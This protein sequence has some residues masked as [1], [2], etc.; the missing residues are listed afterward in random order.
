MASA[1]AVYEVASL[2]RPLPYPRW[3]VY[4]ASICAGRMS[5]RVKVTALILAASLSAAANAAEGNWARVGEALGKTGAELPG[6]I[7]RVALPRTDLKVTLDGVDI[8]PGL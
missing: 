3:Q 2:S 7:Y 6:G 8:K 5:M 1:T 4:I